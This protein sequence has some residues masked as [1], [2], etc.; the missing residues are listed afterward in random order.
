MELKEKIAIGAVVLLLFGLAVAHFGKQVGREYRLRRSLEGKTTFETEFDAGR[1]S[2]DG[3]GSM[4]WTTPQG[5]Y[6][7]REGELCIVQYLSKN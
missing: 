5:T 2:A 3:R 7:Q 1:P 6:M 4:R